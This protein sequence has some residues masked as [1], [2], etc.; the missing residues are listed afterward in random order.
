MAY[1]LE[2]ARLACKLFSKYRNTDSKQK[3]A[4]ALTEPYYQ[5]RDRKN[6]KAISTWIDDEDDEDYDPDEDRVPAKR[7]PQPGTSRTTPV[8]KRTK[9]HSPTPDPT[10]PPNSDTSDLLTHIPPA[11]SSDIDSEVDPWDIYWAIEAGS[12]DNSTPY[13]LRTRKKPTDTEKKEL[14]QAL[15]DSHNERHSDDKE[16]T[17]E[18][19]L[20]C[21]ELE[22][23][24]SSV[25]DP[26]SYPCQ[27]CRDDHLDCEHV[28]APKLKRACERCRHGRRAGL[29]SYLSA[30]YDHAL[31]CQECLE[32]GFQCLA[33]P[34]KHKLD[35]G[36]STDT[37]TEAST[38]MGT[39]TSTDMDSDTGTDM[40]SDMDTDTSTDMGTDMDTDTSTDMGTDN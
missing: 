39:D 14:A 1:T 25:D 33:G 26:Y 16:F 18:G 5:L 23:P 40:G 17:T 13:Q 19:C 32:R 37:E 30:D 15:Q 8:A 34:A 24:C 20:A 12:E 2:R 6:S 31:P 38:D 9:C 10:S 7:K 27:A 21:Q 36:S 3:E 28:P 22:L 29:C 4:E 35:R 11:T